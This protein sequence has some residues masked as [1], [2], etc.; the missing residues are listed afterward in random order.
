MYNIIKMCCDLSP[1]LTGHGMNYF[2]GT[3]PEFLLPMEATSGDAIAGMV[4]EVLKRDGIE[5]SIH[6]WS[7]AQFDKAGHCYRFVI[8]LDPAYV[9]APRDKGRRRERRGD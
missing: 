5:F 8:N 4:R 1:D 3:E 9:P 2:R 7:P 6:R